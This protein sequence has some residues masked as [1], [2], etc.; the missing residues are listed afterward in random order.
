[1]ADEQI[2]YL[3]QEDGITNVR[4][5]L[6]QVQPGRIVFV[7]PPQTHLR[8]NYSWQLLRAD[9]R[10][11]GKEILIVS[12]DRQIRSVAK[13]AGFKVAEPAE[14]TRSSRARPTTSG[15]TAAG[16]RT[17]ARTRTPPDRGASEQ[18][19]RRPDAPSR[20]FTPA[21]GQ[22]PREP[23]RSNE[24]VRKE[25]GTP[26]TA[27]NP[28]SATFGGP[29][30]QFQESF[31]YPVPPSAFMPHVVQPQ[32]EETYD[33]LAEDFREAQ[34]LREAAQGKAADIPDIPSTPPT[35]NVADIPPAQP[36]TMPSPRH[37]PA[38]DLFEHE[39]EMHTLPLAE[40]H[41]S[42]SI[43]S[44]D[45][46]VPEIDD[47]ATELDF[48][49]DLIDLGDQPDFLLQPGS[50]ASSWSHQE[51]EEDQEEQAEEGEEVHDS[52]PTYGA[53]SRRPAESVSPSPQHADIEEEDTQSFPFDDASPGV[54]HPPARRASGRLAPDMGNRGIELRPPTQP[55]PGAA[56]TVSRLRQQPTGR[57]RTATPSRT[58][59]KPSAASRR[60]GVVVMMVLSIVI[61]LCLL[62]GL[63]AYLAP[64]ATV[65]VLL[66]AQNFSVSSIKLT[67]AQGSSQD[68]TRHTLP[69]EQLVFPTSASGKGTAT[70]TTSVG[71]GVAT[72]NVVFS[73]DDPNQPVVIP[74]GTIITTAGNN[75]VQFETTAEALIPALGNFPPVLVQALNPGESGNVAAGLIT[76]IPPESLAK[77]EQANS[78]F[79]RANLKV[80]NPQATSGGGARLVAA[81]AHDDI[82]KLKTVI[83]AQL[84][85]QYQAW[86]AKQKQ[87]GDIVVT[88]NPTIDEKV[89]A[90]PS[91]GQQAA[92]GFTEQIQAQFTVLV[93]RKA[94]LQ[95]AANAEYN[96]VVAKKYPG[97]ALV[98]RQSVS[99]SKL[100]STTASNHKSLA[101]SFDAAGQI[102]H[103]VSEQDVR[104]LLSGK[105]VHDLQPGRQVKGVQHYQ[106]AL[107]ANTT[108]DTTIN[109][110]PDYF[111]WLP[112]RAER[113]NVQFQPST[114]QSGLP[115]K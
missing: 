105:L 53:P 39:E 37:E 5:R 49:G 12:S 102:A 25:D 31:D 14:S 98:P 113:I 26:G 95:A 87:S 71:S 38:G 86:L 81:V 57:G 54:V 97:Q 36:F 11:L 110:N 35:E 80:I 82:N 22:P 99:L 16:G 17:T 8:S 13:A 70:G 18:R 64:T 75:P 45:D 72:G 23:D 63:V 77:I 2:I 61:L 109:V 90:T 34:S 48:E 6:E 115:N 44:L 15:R 9:A 104:S 107:G 73:N 58:A 85:S 1:M 88:G 41:A 32:E 30:E 56:R 60:S 108:L 89:T 67:A 51:S 42:V 59:A 112:F 24:Q 65:T 79:N 100:S 69:A 92:D 4:Q 78:N 103:T 101:L 20:R 55:R 27:H 106:L 33:S 50:H 43:P 46:D 74:Q 93:V 66:P 47:R 19:T 40:Q 68:V 111:P 114:T 84:Q 7:V 52:R 21:P 3:G 94:A 83:D 28:A 96:A 76:V 62:L 10:R 29:D 91:E